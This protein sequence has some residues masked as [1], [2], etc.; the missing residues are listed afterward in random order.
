MLSRISIYKL[1]AIL[2][3]LGIILASY[4][5]WP[6]SIIKYI[7]FS[8]SFTLLLYFSF[9]RLLKYWCQLQKSP[10]TM[11][12]YPLPT[13][14]K[15]LVARSTRSEFFAVRVLVGISAAW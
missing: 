6:G 4:F 12:I 13:S 2:I 1:A 14:K 9:N 8:I 15:S 5:A 3:L 11:V 7:I 10:Q